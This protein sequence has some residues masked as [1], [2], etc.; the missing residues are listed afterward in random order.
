[1]KNL[2]K[3]SARKGIIFLTEAV[4]YFFFGL[5]SWIKSH[6]RIFQVKPGTFVVMSCHWELAIGKWTRNVRHAKYLCFFCI[7]RAFHANLSQFGN[8]FQVNLVRNLADSLLDTHCVS[9]NNKSLILVWFSGRPDIY[10]IY[11]SVYF[12]SWELAADTPSM[13][14]LALLMR[15]INEMHSWKQKHTYPNPWF[16]RTGIWFLVLR[17]RLYAQCPLRLSCGWFY[18]LIKCT[19]SIFS[20]IMLYLH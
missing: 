11:V 5:T 4:L 2:R 3:N 1:M 16:V 17:L 20:F 10:T 9:S 12:F 7:V 8:N 18:K 19:W 15:I 6:F 13:R 14:N